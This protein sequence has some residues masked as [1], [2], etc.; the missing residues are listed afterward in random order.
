MNDRPDIDEKIGDLLRRELPVPE[1][2][3]GYREDVAARITAEAV[4][5]TSRKKWMPEL[6]WPRAAR[7]EE[8]AGV[9]KRA[10][11]TRRPSGLRVAAYASIAVVLV[12]AVAIGSLEAVKHLG[13]DQ[14]ILVITDDTLSPASTGQTTQTTQV[15]TASTGAWEQLPVSVEGGVVNVLVMDPS[16]PAVLYA[17]TDEGLFKSTDGAASWTQLSVAG[18]VTTIAVDPGSPSTVCVSAGYDLYRSLDGGATW[19]HPGG[20]PGWEVCQ[21]WLDSSTSPSTLFSQ[22]GYGFGPFKSTDGGSTWED[23]S[24]PEKQI[25]DLAVDPH[26]GTLYAV[27][28]HTLCRSS[29]GGATWEDVSAGIPTTLT[30][31]NIIVTLDPRDP[32]RLYLYDV[33]ESGEPTTLRSV[34]VSLD[35]GE[36]WSELAGAKLDWAKAVLHSAP[37]TPAGAIEAAAAFLRDFTGTV[38]D[39]SSGDEADV[40]SFAWGYCD[41][42]VVDPDD[43]SI[44]YVPTESGVYKSND[45]GK[46]WNRATAGMTDSAVYGV[47]VDPLSPSTIYATTSASVVKSTDGGASWTAILDSCGSLALAPSLPSRLYARTADGLLRSDDGGA[48]WTKL[49]TSGQGSVSLASGAVGDFLVSGMFV[50]SDRPDTILANDGDAGVLLSTD[51]G[52]TWRAVAGR[53]GLSQVIAEAPDDPSTF[54]A[55][56][57]PFGIFKSTDGGESWAFATQSSG[58]VS[59]LALAID[60]SNPLTI[61]AVQDGNGGFDAND[62]NAP[63]V[64]RST[65]GGATWTQAN[66]QG[67]SDV[68]VSQGLFYD[69]RTPGMLYAVTTGETARVFRSLDGGATWQ[70]LSEGGLSHR[71]SNSAVLDPAPGGG[72]Y[73]ATN[74]GLY[75]WVPDSI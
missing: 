56:G 36:T 39:P 53:P 20:P 21:F 32:S 9:Q 55:G 1:H 27:L 49:G 15:P 6:R 7:V 8:R 18:R 66:F 51:G 28:Y 69:A 68:I 45:Q 73:W 65:D 40:V 71:W 54:Y 25:F 70:D 47:L 44:L 75:R 5:R 12:A 74:H 35:R 33:P 62:P 61:Y 14:P 41:E 59:V 48:T 2:R 72:L 63:L 50:A 16:D 46:T 57:I 52:E 13:K 19:T 26:D 31:H 58:P 34:F 24:T 22:G 43:P 38:T 11:A 64:W 10:S 29:D 3:E 4:T 60:P 30:C 17:G 67:L 42:V 37:G 23:V